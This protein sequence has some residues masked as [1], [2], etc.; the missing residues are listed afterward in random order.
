MNGLEKKLFQ[1]LI[2]YINSP[3]DQP[4]QA[5][6]GWKAPNPDGIRPSDTQLLQE[7]KHI[8]AGSVNTGHPL[9]VNRL[10]G[11]ADR[12]AVFGA[13]LQATL[14]T[15]MG[16]DQM[17]PIFMQMERQVLR[18]MLTKV[19]FNPDSSTATF[20]PG[21]SIGNLYGLH[22]ARN[23]AHKRLGHDR[24]DSLAVICSDR[25][26]YSVSRMAS[27]SG[28]CKSNIL[29]VRCHKDETMDVDHLCTV[30]SEAKE[31]GLVPFFVNA[32]AGT[33]VT[34]GFD[35]VQAIARVVKN[36]NI[37]LHVDASWGG[38][39][40]LCDDY[41]LEMADSVAWCMHKMMGVPLHAAVVMFKDGK[42]L[43]KAFSD[44]K[45]DYIYQTGLGKYS[46]QCSR[47]ADAVKAWMMLRYNG[48]LG[49]FREKTKVAQ[50]N[51]RLLWNLINSD[52]YPNLRPIHIN[53]PEFSNVCFWYSRDPKLFEDFEIIDECLFRPKSEK[54]AKQ[55]EAW[56]K[57]E[58]E[59]LMNDRETYIAIAS[60]PEWDMPC[61]FRVNFVNHIEESHIREMLELFSKQ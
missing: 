61:F 51:A 33:T 43:F 48:G 12:G 7:M 34:G 35:D 47:P 4:L 11:G 23:K 56:I 22:V 27:V 50:R 45:I 52:E 38:A 59:R 29:K 37:H 10:F 25:A 30:I 24:M 44:D 41:S 18:L 28:V 60:I 5:E 1:L 36:D 55:I 40:C 17:A 54:T 31:R 21:G 6:T 13:F 58:R 42:A 2:P 32:T 16:D 15:S 19:G 3:E 46:L 20:A 49:V 14:N 9:F 39:R 8:I 57:N 26:H 53:A